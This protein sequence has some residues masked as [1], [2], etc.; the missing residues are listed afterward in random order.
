MGPKRRYS[1]RDSRL[2]LTFLL[3]PFNPDLQTLTSLGVSVFVLEV[4]VLIYDK[5]GKTIMNLTM[6]HMYVIA[7]G[8]YKETRNRIE[9]QFSGVIYSMMMASVIKVRE[10]NIVWPPP[11]SY[12]H[13]FSHHIF[14]PSSFD[15]FVLEYLFIPSI[16]SLSLVPSTTLQNI[17]SRNTHV[18]EQIG[19]KAIKR[20]KSLHTL[21]ELDSFAATELYGFPSPDH[22]DL[23]C[24][25][26]SADFFAK[27]DVPYLVIQPRD[28][29]L[30]AV[31]G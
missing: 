18:H 20:L 4:V 22:Y 29:P 1:W 6:N 28:D 24:P 23:A 30:H 9:K 25:N 19:N 7:L 14:S 8:N 15:S 16:T 2:E 26:M 12:S 10:H 5:D 27:I 3:G 11:T 17:I 21:S 13:P 31:R